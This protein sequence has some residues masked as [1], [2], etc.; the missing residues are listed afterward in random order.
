MPTLF[1]GDALLEVTPGSGWLARER[2]RVVWVPNALDID[3]AHRCIEPLLVEE[4]FDAVLDLIAKWP[5]PEVPFVLV[6]SGEHPRL[7]TYGFEV[8][9][10][11]DQ[12]HLQPVPLHQDSVVNV[13]RIPHDIRS[14]QSPL[15]HEQASGMLNE[16]VIRAGGWKWHAA[17]QSAASTGD[18]VRWQLASNYGQWEISE[19]LR[20]GRYGGTPVEGSALICVPDQSVSRRHAWISLSG[21]SPQIVDEDSRNGTFVVRSN[22]EALNVE[23]SSPLTLTDGD[24]IVVGNTSFLVQK[25]LSE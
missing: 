21:D 10:A 25:E 23:A 2:D 24:L 7:V 12:L 9:P 15:G 6:S 11:N 4:S 20:I 8:R 19:S 17:T 16:G 1:E 22:G 14:T 18:A 13:Q 3:R 5:E